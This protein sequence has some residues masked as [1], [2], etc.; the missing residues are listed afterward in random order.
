MASLQLAGAVEV[1][2][3][4]LDTLGHGL[5]ALAH[6]HS[7][8]VVPKICRSVHTERVVGDVQAYFLLG[9]SSPSGLP[10]W[11]LT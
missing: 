2:E 6:P 9:L 10:T 7:G 8:V 5:L 1:L 4:R 3:R 11:L